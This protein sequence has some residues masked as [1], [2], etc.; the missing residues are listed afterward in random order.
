M[1]AFSIPENS[2]DGEGEWASGNFLHSAERVLVP[3]VLKVCASCDAVKCSTQ[4]GT[5]VSRES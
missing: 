1:E 4:L 5:T 3:S 2:E